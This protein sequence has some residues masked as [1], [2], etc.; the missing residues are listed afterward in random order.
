M[1]FEI[2]GMF[3]IIID[4]ITII[5]YNRNFNNNNSRNFN[6]DNGRNYNNN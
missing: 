1:I 2:M 6:N 3:I 5:I 4:H